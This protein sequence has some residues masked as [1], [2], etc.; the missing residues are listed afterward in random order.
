MV[1]LAK[2]KTKTS[3]NAP[4]ET[5]ALS[6]DSIEKPLR[7][8]L[9]GIGA[10][11]GGLEALS[12]MIAALP[13][14][15]GISY[16]V[17]QHLSPTHRSMMVQLLGRETAMAVT[18][19][20]SGL[21]PQPDTIYVAPA[22]CNV[23][24][25]DGGF[26]LIEGPREAT[27]RPSVNVFL[28]SLAE[29]KIENA[30]GVIL[31]GTGSDGAAGL[32]DI[33]AAGGYTFAQDPQ[34]AKYAGMPQSA[35][36][37]GCVDW[38]LSPEGIANEI[39]IIARSHGT[40]TVAREAPVA[41]TTLKKLLMKVKQQTRIDFSGYKEGTLWRRIERRM[42]ACHITS[43]ND[44]LTLAD[45][46]PEELEHLG[47]D[48][49]ISV[50]AFF[51]DPESFAALRNVL[52][53]VV[54]TK[55]PGDEIRIWVA[56]CATGEE[57][58]TVAILLSEILGPN[59]IQFRI[60]IFATDID[61]NALSIARKGSY[62]E[63]ALADLDPSLVV[64]HFQKV[65]NRYE[66]SRTLRDMVV[67]A[68][69]DLV[70]DPPFLRLDMVSCRNM[71]IYLQNELQ[72]KVLATFHYS[73]Y[74]GG[75]LFLGKSEGVFQQDALFDVA[76]KTAR[77]YRRRIGD[78]RLTIPSFRLPD[79][80]ERTTG[81]VQPPDAERR[82]VEE[83]MR[84]YAPSSVLINN[85][86]DILQIHGDVGAYLAVVAG[87]P[88]FNLQHLLRRELRADL[89]I[90][91]HH[92][93]HKQE[94]AVGRPHTIKVGETKHDMRIAVHPLELLNTITPLF[95]V[96][97]EVL[98]EAVQVIEG[99]PSSSLS[100]E[101]RNVQELED[102]LIST[103]ERLQ[104]VIEELETSN[105]E[106]QALNEEVQAANEELQSSNE[107]LESTN[108]ELQST[109]EELTTV[110]EELQVRS[111]E[112]A[113][114]LNDL[115][116]I[117]NSVGF[118]ILVCNENLEV[119]R[120]NSPA[121]A[122]FSLSKASLRQ[123]IPAL[124]LPVGM[125]DFS[126]VVQQAIVSNHISEEHIFSNERHYLLH[127][128]P[129]ETKLRAHRGA[130]IVMLDYTE[131]LAAEREVRKNREILLAIMN[132]STAIVALKDLAGRYEFVNRQFERFFEVEAI[133]VL[134]KTDAQ[135]FP[136]KQADD[137]RSKELEVVRHKTVLEFEDQIIFPSGRECF[138][139]SVRFP[140]LAEDGEVYSVCTQAMDV[141]EHK[142]AEDQ[143]RLAARVF[144]RAGEGI[145][146]TDA[147]QTILTVNGAFTQ[148]TGYEAEE[149]I[150]KTPSILS[151]GRH[152]ATFYHDLW[153]RLLSQ[154][155]WQG[156][157]VNKRKNGDTYPEWLTINAVRDTQGDIVN[158]VGIFSDI[159]VVKESQRRVEFLATHDELTGLPNRTL[160]LDRLRQAIA[161]TVRDDGT[162][163]VLFVD[164]DNFKVVND[165]L[166]H[167]AGDELLKEISRRLR[168]CVRGPDTVARFGGDEFALLIEDA[169]VAEAEMT[170]QRIAESMLHPYSIGRQNVYPGASIGICLYP[171]DGVDPE[172][173][174]KNADSAMYKAKDGGKN[175]HHFFTEE[176]KQAADERL[177]LETG[178]RG[179]IRREELSLVFQPQWDI[180]TRRMVGVEAL[181]RWRN[182]DGQI[183][184][185]KFIPLAEKIGMMDHLGEWI[186]S[187]ACKQMAAWLKK[188]YDIPQISINISAEQFRRGN[189]PAMML[190]LLS[191]HRLDAS[192]VMLELTESALTEDIDSIQQVLL[193]L[194]SLGVKISIDDFG[195][196][197]SSL[198]YLRKLPINELKIP[199]EFVR[200]IGHDA[201][202]QAIAKTI[203]A[204][205]ETL[206]FSVVAEG[207]ETEVQLEVLKTLGCDIAQG[208]LLAM[209]M[210]A[211]EL[212]ERYFPE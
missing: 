90:L 44:Y 183:S 82:L 209:P 159:S 96:C 161:H 117:Q 43:L 148:V 63:S 149:V 113:D 196:G 49:L 188:G 32:R 175:T 107:E 85:S 203:L 29:D 135:V 170:A 142:R 62:A 176:L 118:P 177:K 40:V 182:Q 151:S 83:T 127:I 71:L 12:S 104:T 77:I 193:E 123:V 67:V 21:H 179:A 39:A 95:L 37:T 53:G 9:V 79:G 80:N 162:F 198:A 50:T 41:A 38:I 124:R 173:L 19:V 28:N 97:F 33:K 74:P 88:N 99:A 105:E 204:M 56:A 189:V 169:T 192:Q 14:D 144:D 166:G 58:Y 207:I 46:N 125:K 108:E 34:T 147:S 4:S 172:T 153:E 51:R 15:L 114:L 132:N 171:N 17:L 181:A 92:A 68:R 131:R 184:P 133:N 24:L 120:F 42:A 5:A 27:P 210:T 122:L 154:G 139:H 2:N 187:T 152:E 168:D 136:R 138:L 45:T 20:E 78:S 143:L 158:Y 11:A 13:T 146:V 31:S 69:Q 200:E 197:Y 150:G 87:K 7:P 130:I 93:E 72:S 47:K 30:I 100:A 57:A 180:A 54:Q 101:G 70:Q 191:Q 36:D 141:S 134:G 52:R 60:Q 61:L 48:I 145:M 25:K 8:Y 163:A 202:D 121:A 112:L 94:S 111:T 186:A 160:F 18:E 75:L 103:R 110:N 194:K 167:A 208:F 16:V 212:V 174:L 157:I 195:S 66:V 128:S 211:E 206:G 102:E 201:D 26:V 140:L 115:E 59:A 23:K 129:Y 98:P 185:T 165:S 55:Q 86:F 155:W 109:N 35:I 10:S 178:L 164:L 116:N 190:R 65:G 126:S 22:S 1:R 73:L 89:Q 84:R 3:L 91:Q 156:E 137:F 6:A 76:D 106:M 199:Q 81:K 119:T 64:R 205:A